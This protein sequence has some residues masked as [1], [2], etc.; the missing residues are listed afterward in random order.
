MFTLEGKLPSPGSNKSLSPMEVPSILKQRHPERRRRKHSFSPWI[1]SLQTRAPVR[2]E[3]TI[4]QASK[5]FLQ[6]HNW[7]W[8]NGCGKL[9]M[10]RECLV[11]VTP[12]ETRL[13]RQVEGAAQGRCDR[14]GWCLVRGGRSWWCGCEDSP[15]CFIQRISN[16]H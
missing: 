14:Y 13:L 5:T 1:P 15:R 4:R 12:G 9:P 7:Q 11:R 8:L 6:K 10:V 3:S 16:T 2:L